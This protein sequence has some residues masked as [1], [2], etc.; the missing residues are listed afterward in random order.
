MAD[1]L[2]PQQQAQLEILETLPPKFEV[3]NRIVPLRQ[4]I[5]LRGAGAVDFE[6]AGQESIRRAQPS[7]RG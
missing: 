5:N 2:T 7:P 6:R 4:Q 3:I 1:K